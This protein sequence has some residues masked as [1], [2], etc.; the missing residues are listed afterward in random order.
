[1]VAAKLMAHWRS[2]LTHMPFTH[3]FMGSNPVWVTKEKIEGLIR[4]C[5]SFFVL[6]F[7]A[8]LCYIIFVD[9]QELNYDQEKENFDD[10]FIIGC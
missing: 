8:H 3:A 2:G 4:K 1:M 5:Q 7:H 10:C 9:S 6:K